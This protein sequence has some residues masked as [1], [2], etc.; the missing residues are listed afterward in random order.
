M[1]SAPMHTIGRNPRMRYGWRPDTPDHRDLP[2]L[3]GVTRVPSAVSLRPHCPPVYDQGDLG[4]CTA[5]ALCNAFRFAVL[6][7]P[8]SRIRDVAMFAP[9]RLFLYYEERKLENTVASDAGA[10]IRDG[11]KVLH[12]TGVCQETLCPY[13]VAKFAEAPSK[14]ALADALT[15]QSITYL[16]VAGTEAAL[17][18]ALAAGYPVVVGISVYES[19]ESAAVAKTGTVPL[20][21]RNEELLGGHAILCIG[22]DDA[23]KRFTLMNSWGDGWGDKGYFTLPYGYLGNPDLASD[24]WAIETVER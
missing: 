1:S 2:F 19:F 4:S 12:T 15:H 11:A 24:F 16:R 14:A 3:A 17:K 7:Q 8:A 6:Q 20:P 23:A 22:Y 9:S 21:K 5:N 13:D 10:E 18:A